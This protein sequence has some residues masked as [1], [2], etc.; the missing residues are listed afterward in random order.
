MTHL[1][2]KGGGAFESAVEMP[3]WAHEEIICVFYL[4]VAVLKATS[5]KEEI[6]HR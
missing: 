5:K 2:R 3:G 4:H 1:R 6:P